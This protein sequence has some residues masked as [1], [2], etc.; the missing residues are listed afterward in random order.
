MKFRFKP[1][2]L[3]IMAAVFFTAV[4]ISLGKWQLRQAER[5]TDIIALHEANQLKPAL[6][7]REALADAG[8]RQNNR[9][10][11]L[12]GTPIPDRQFLL[13]NKV[14]MGRVGF[15]VLTPFVVEND[16]VV[17]LVDRGWQAMGARRSDL[18][19]ISIAAHLMDIEGALSLSEKGFTLGGMDEGE[20]GWPRIIQYI[21]FNKIEGLLEAKLV[22]FV[23]RLAD[24]PAAYIE[25]PRP[26][27]TIT[28]DKHKGYAFQWFAMAA[29]VL[30]LFVALNL[31]RR[32]DHD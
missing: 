7:L 24:H 17:V 19:D 23:V 3:V 31:K 6:P 10:V 26:V 22:P 21:D 11:F 27:A 18:P 20:R 8:I 13:D 1:P 4:F 9:R 2:V 5:K 14:F 32:K 29:A 30:V 15:D 28:P 12:R 25:R 16:S